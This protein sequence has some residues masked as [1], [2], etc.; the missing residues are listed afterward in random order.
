MSTG[1]NQSESKRFLRQVDLLVIV[2][3]IPVLFIA[4][5]SEAWWTLNGTDNGKLLMIKV[6]PYY[7]SIV[8]TGVTSNASV[9]PI[10]GSLGRLIAILSFATLLLS[11]LRPVAWWRNLA[12]H[13]GL[14]G[15]TTLYFI[16]LIMYHSAQAAFLTTYNVILPYAGTARIQANIL[17]LDMK[18]YPSPLVTA[19]FSI[20]FF[21][22]LLSIALGTGSLV[23]NS[24]RNR[25]AAL[26]GLIPTGAKEI[27]LS[28]PYRNIWMS[29]NDTELNPLSE[30]PDHTTDDQL[31]VSF[32]KLYRT[33][34]PGGSLSIILPA[35][36]T[37]IEDRLE[38]L[39][40]HTGFNIEVARLVYRTPGVPETELRFRKPVDKSIGED[41]AQTDV[42][43]EP[44]RTV[45][46]DIFPTQGEIE[47]DDKLPFKIVPVVPEWSPKRIT[48][49]ERA[50]LRSA[51]R[52]INQRQAPVPYR[53]LL[54]QVYL[55]LVDRKLNFESSREI[56]NI[57]LKHTGME[58]ELVEEP[59]ATGSRLIRKWWLGE[60][61]ILLEKESDPNWLTR[62]AS[63]ARGV[64]P[65]FRRKKG[66]RK[67]S[68]YRP[69]LRRED[70]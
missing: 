64:V 63:R 42:K 44:S 35:W 24:L 6:S 37:S 14:T 68:R 29:T 3:A 60:R 66:W 2:A 58:L 32:E 52:M 61:K 12:F 40:P 22:G 55:D 69:S 48:S 17:G 33:I 45:K 23:G 10:L 20:S 9:M 38:K 5:S 39:L 13:T 46:I 36:A 41:V 8:A 11:G 49:L 34:N 21:L 54:N 16:F 28:P 31:L 26:A 4:L 7:V 43:Q 62:F 47:P 25:V 27:H 30:D 67:E 15:L 70:D 50:M 59:D 51:I 53:E 19:G 1:A 18:N 56:E 65:D 57:L